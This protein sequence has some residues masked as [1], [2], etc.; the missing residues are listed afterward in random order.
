MSSRKPFPPHPYGPMPGASGCCVVCGLPEPQGQHPKGDGVTDDTSV[1]QAAMRAK[2]TKI[3]DRAPKAADAR[4][5]MPKERES[6]THRAVV[7]GFRFYI[8]AGKYEDGSLGEVF[9]KDA[10]KEGSTVQGLL[11]GFATA[12]SIALQHGATLEQVVAKFA[13]ANFE[14]RG[15][16]ENPEIPYA[17]SVL[18]YTVRWLALHFGSPELNAKLVDTTERMRTRV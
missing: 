15:E 3:R 9:V 16:T 14:P 13:H 8:T 1:I 7:G 12:V 4:K 2:A 10:G 5:R 11:D 17:F 18:D 6:L